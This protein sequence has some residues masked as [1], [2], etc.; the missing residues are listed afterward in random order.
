VIA[1]GCMHYYLLVGDGQ[2]G[3]VVR[4]GKA[5]HEDEDRHPDASTS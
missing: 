2:G 4:A 5:G 3:G 1:M